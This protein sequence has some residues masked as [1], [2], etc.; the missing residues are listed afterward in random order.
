MGP[1]LPA[2]CVIPLRWSPGEPCD[3]MTAY[4]GRLRDWLDVTVVDGSEPVAFAEHARAWGALVRHV[5][6]ACDRGANGKV[7]GVLTGLALARHEIVVLADD[8]VR[9]DRATLA[10]LVAAAAGADLVRPQNHFDPLPWHA[11]WDTA[12]SLLNRAVACDSP[13]TYAVCRS[14]LLPGGYDADV[15]FE[16]LEMERTV[17]ARGGVVLD[18]PDILVVR[19]PPEVRQFLDQRVRQAYDD[20]AQPGRLLLEAAVLPVLLG[21]RHRARAAGLLALALVGL[22]EVGRRRAGGPR[23]LPGVVGAVG[24]GVGRRARRDRLARAAAAAARRCA[25]PRPPAAPRRDPGAGAAPSPRDPARAGRS[26]VRHA[27]G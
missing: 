11:R 1:R 17:R 26:A 5:P 14:A 4:L 23:R 12:R 24:A 27:Q 20:L 2:E 15:L 16:N 6:V 10:R 19:R 18:R 13:G 8:D 25:V 21:S 22:A 9:H 7:N 3:E